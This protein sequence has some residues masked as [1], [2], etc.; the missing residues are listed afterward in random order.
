MSRVAYDIPGAAEASGVSRR[1]IEMAISDG[2]LTAR[3]C[4]E[5][6]LVTHADLCRWVDGMTVWK[7]T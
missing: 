7:A 2:S 1:A 4:E 5:K 6:P 3:K